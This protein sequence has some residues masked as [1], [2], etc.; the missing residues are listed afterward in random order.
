MW[1]HPSLGKSR[2]RNFTSESRDI[3]FPL[4]VTKKGSSGFRANLLAILSPLTRLQGLIR[5]PLRLAINLLTPIF[6]LSVFVFQ[7]VI[8]NPSFDRIMSLFRM[9]ECSL[10]SF[11][12]QISPILKQPKTPMTTMVTMDLV[13]KSLKSEFFKMSGSMSTVIGLLNV[14]VEG[15]LV[16]RKCFKVV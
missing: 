11:L 13:V 12:P 3:G 7:S 4:G 8:F 15:S 6:L 10:P 14:R 1:L 5:Q 9:K 16:F 2:S